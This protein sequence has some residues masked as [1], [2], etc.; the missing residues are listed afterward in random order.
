MLFRQKKT[1]P[2][3]PTG[4]CKYKY[5]KIYKKEWFC[6]FCMNFYL[7]LIFI[8]KF[9]LKYTNLKYTKKFVGISQLRIFYFLYFTGCIYC[10]KHFS[11]LFMQ[12]CFLNKCLNKNN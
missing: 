10:K 11:N 4:I 7:L 8:P 3:D 12:I 1:D 6:L 9:Y 5:K 2:S